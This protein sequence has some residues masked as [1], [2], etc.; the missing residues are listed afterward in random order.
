MRRFVTEFLSTCII[1]LT[2]YIIKLEANEKR[3]KSNFIH[4]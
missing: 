2:T 3:K 1:I 4:I